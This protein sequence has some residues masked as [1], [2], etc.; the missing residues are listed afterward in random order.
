MTPD[1]MIVRT[2][3]TLDTVQVVRRWAESS[4]WHEDVVRIE[5]DPDDI[6]MATCQRCGWYAFGGD[7]FSVAVC[8]KV[9]AETCAE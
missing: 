1:R 6:L 8:E 3:I 2:G 7:V 5:G 4:G 9:H